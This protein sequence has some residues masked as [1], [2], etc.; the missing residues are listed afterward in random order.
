[1]PQSLTKV[2][3]TNYDICG[4]KQV[5][6]TLFANSRSKAIILYPVIVSMRNSKNKRIDYS[7]SHL[8]K[9]VSYDES[10]GDFVPR[11]WHW[12]AEKEIIS[13]CVVQLSRQSRVLDLATGTGR[14]AGFMRN[15]LGF[16][17]ILGVDVSE[18]MLTVARNKYPGV[19]F[20]N[21][22][23]R[24]TA[25]AREFEFI[26]AFRFFGKADDELLNRA[27]IFI[28]KALVGGGILMFNNH[29]N[30]RS[31]SSNFLSLTRRQRYP[32]RYDEE[33]IRAFIS[34]GYK[35]LSSFSIGVTP[36]TGSKFYL[37]K[38]ASIL[39]EETNLKWF[40]RHHKLGI[41]N[42]FCLRKPTTSE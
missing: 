14:I 26:S 36:Q 32:V 2:G 31:L 39:M 22:D 15:S 33:I 40:T 13:S 38:R 41:N 18:E 12:K 8:N 4:H 23:V 9:G 3:P 29:C 5:K 7:S 1:M 34:K 37:G 27:V 16:T 20:R 28:D 35:V 25:F 19:V 42:I 17:D 11:S 10:F 24:R 21:I 6:G 30:A